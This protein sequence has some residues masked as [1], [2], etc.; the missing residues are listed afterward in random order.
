ML[1]SKSDKSSVPGPHT[2][3]APDG[4]SPCRLSILRNANVACLCRLFKAMS[5]VDFRKLPCRMS[6]YFV[7]H[8]RMSLGP[9]SHVEFKKQPCR[10]VDFRGQGPYCDYY[11]SFSCILRDI[12]CVF[13]SVANWRIS[14]RLTRIGQLLQLGDLIG[15]GLLRFIPAWKIDSQS[16]L[17]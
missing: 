17:N 16:L 4:G 2:C 3:G 1:I 6:L 13:R 8:C 7:K 5:P 12:L 14:R 10:P 11:I 15:H 9:M